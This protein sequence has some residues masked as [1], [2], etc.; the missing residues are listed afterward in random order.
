MIVPDAV[1]GT[2][3]AGSASKH[4]VEMGDLSFEIEVLERRREIAIRPERTMLY[5]EDFDAERE[6]IQA[7]ETGLT[8]RYRRA[9]GNPPVRVEV[10]RFG[11]DRFG[12]WFTSRLAGSGGR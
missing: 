6:L 2:I 1:L 5:R 12:P 9:H 3:E 7:L 4:R 8:C 10:R 11:P